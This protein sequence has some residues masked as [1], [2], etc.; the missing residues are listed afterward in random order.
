[1]ADLLA[2]VHADGVPA[3]GEARM[4][5][6][7]LTEHNP[8]EYRADAVVTLLANGKAVLAVIVEV[9]RGEDKDKRWSWPAYVGT[10]RARQRCPVVLLVISPDARIASWCRRPIRLGHPGLVLTPLVLGPEETPVVTDPREAVANPMLMVLSA[11][12]HGAEADGEKV[13]ATLLGALARFEKDLAQEYIDEVIAVLPQGA[14]DLLEA[15]V[16][17]EVREWKSEF[18]R[19]HVRQGKA[20]GKAE[21]IL[22]VLLARGIDVPE[23][24][25][26]R[27]V[28]CTDLNQLNTWV[29]RAATADSI[30][31]LFE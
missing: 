27:I 12:V 6:G 19:R 20:E 24:A 15:M 25:H 16:A 23:D 26:V 7:D 8:T 29:D 22:R 30:D 2:C 10:L 28:E 14:R 3:F 1:M 13:F 21:D 4:E 5:S 9:Q 11:M 18:F 31:D 17:T